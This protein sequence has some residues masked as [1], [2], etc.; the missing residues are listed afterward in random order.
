M[1][2]EISVTIQARRLRF[3]IQILETM[4]TTPTLM[5][6]VLMFF[7]IFINLVNFYRLKKNVCHSHSL[8]KCSNFFS[9][10]C[11]FCQFLSVYQKHCSNASTNVLKIFLISSNFPILS[12]CQNFAFIFPL[13]KVTC[14]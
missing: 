6:N 5:K 2:V 8:K 4:M 7:H 10:Y 13:V 3:R 1:N 14:I 12:I 9:F 11:L